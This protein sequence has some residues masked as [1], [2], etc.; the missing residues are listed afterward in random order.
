MTEDVP[1]EAEEI[2]D[3][4]SA[5]RRSSKVNLNH[6]VEIIRRFAGAQVSFLLKL[7]EWIAQ[8]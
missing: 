4:K 6:P 8:F 5:I 7:H 1:M 2:I 3:N